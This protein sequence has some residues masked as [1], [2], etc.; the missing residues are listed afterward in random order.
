MQGVKTTL[1]LLG[2]A[3]LLAAFGQAVAPI[4]PPFI[5]GALLAYIGDPLVDRLELRG[6][7]RNQAVALVFAILSLLVLGLLLVIVPLL[8]QQLATLI[9][10]LPDYLNTVQQQGLPKLA[11]WLHLPN[12][13][14][15]LAA[16]L[17]PLKS[18]GLQQTQ[19][20]VGSIFSLLS[21]S[22]LAVIYW[23]GHLLLLPVVTFYLLRDWDRLVAAIGRLIPR[24]L[25][26]TLLWMAQEADTMLGAFFR[27]QLTVALLL[28]GIYS[29]GLWWVG[30]EFSLLIGLIAGMV[31]IAPYLGFV[32]GI[33]LSTV[34]ALMQFHDWSPL[35]PIVMVFT[36][37]QL[38]EGFLLTPLLLGNKLGLHP[39]LVLLAVLAGGE[40]AGFW[41]VLVALPVAAVLA[42]WL[43][44]AIGCYLESSW[45]KDSGASN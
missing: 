38:L 37:A 16:L 23:I 44:R 41:G 13:A 43:R 42:V 30:L 35:L 26:P 11:R 14:L 28:G 2:V 27:G 5:L 17:Q 29:I 3:L 32:V 22:G 25:Y 7:S 45:Y 33:L 1:L 15:S 36:V 40:L 4:L 10:R 18:A 24:P 39:L 19:Q 31:S 34:A 12:D 20:T 8:Q 9:A 21:S 6:L